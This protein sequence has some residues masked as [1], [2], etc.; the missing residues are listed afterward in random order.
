M[1]YFTA[2]LHLGHKNILKYCNRPFKSIE[3]MD[4]TI[5]C[6]WL[7]LVKEKDT[8]YI[9]GDFTFKSIAPYANQLSGIKYLLPGSHDKIKY[10]DYFTNLDG[11]N[12]LPPILICEN[13]G[14]KDEYGNKRSITLCHYSLRTWSKSHYGSWHLFGHSHGRLESYGL[15][16]DV[17]VDT[18]NFFPYSLNDVEKKMSTLMP[19]VDYR[20]K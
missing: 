7:S 3:E 17:G 1:I 5:I 19:I 12:I 2:D 15:S 9:L 20:S 10:K 18:N 16:F 11:L 14:L 8:V 4:E 6:N 13:F